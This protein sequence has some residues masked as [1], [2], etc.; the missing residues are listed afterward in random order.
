MYT[1]FVIYNLENHQNRKK[2]LS[3]RYNYVQNQVINSTCTY[4]HSYDIDFDSVLTGHCMEKTETDVLDD[5]QEDD[6]LILLNEPF[7]SEHEQ[8][9]IPL[10]PF[11]NLSTNE[12]CTSLFRT[13]R[14]ANLCKTYSSKMLQLIHSA[15]PQPNNL[16]TSVN[17]LLKYIHGKLI[18]LYILG[19][20]HNINVKFCFLFCIF[21]LVENLFVKRRICLVCQLDIEYNAEL[22]T[23][24]KSKDNMQVADV[25]H[26]DYAA[27]F[28]DLIER[29][30][31]DITQYTEKI[32]SNEKDDNNNDIPFQKMYRS[33]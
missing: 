4:H 14:E 30:V 33:F 19:S 13:F 15:L 10:H 23:K 9:P 12:F 2:K 26:I 17:T 3:N 8:V 20:I 32:M 25:F 28:A 11:T 6:N 16:P 22:C 5:D 27:A 31:V 7:L 18:L 21:C 1:V 24:C 29:H